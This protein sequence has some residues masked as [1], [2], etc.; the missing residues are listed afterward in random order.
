MSRI[1]ELATGTP[2]ANDAI[3]FDGS[4]G[5]K[6]LAFKDLA[7]AA[8]A[9]SSN[10]AAAFHN[11]IYRGANLKTLWGL[12]LASDVVAK[13]TTN[14]ANGTFEDLFIGDYFDVSINTSIGGTETV[15][16]VIAG[17]DVYM[18]CGD[19][20]L[21]KHHAVIVPKDCFKTT[22]QMNSS[23]VTTGGYKGSAM[24][25]NILPVYAAALQTALNNKIINHREILSKTVNTN[26]TSGA[27]AGWTGASS[28]WEWSDSLIELMSEPEV[29]GG[30]VL[31]SSF[32]DVG[33]AKAQL[34]LFALNPAMIQAN[35]NGGSRQ[36]Y[37]LKAVAASTLFCFVNINGHANYNN[38]SNSYGVRPRFL[39]G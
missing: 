21:T 10:N 13:V 27:Y 22:S 14:I 34:P 8:L 30:R 18:N 2:S 17:F 32:Y 5:T 24:Y 1:N 9:K 36:W 35:K 15:T 23:N 31:S 4:G 16:C 29:Y 33:I 11:S 12:T 20:A 3:V 28:D 7:I 25:Q 19:T 6:K 38:A 39:I 37:W 26:A